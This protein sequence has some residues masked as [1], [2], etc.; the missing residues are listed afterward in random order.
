MRLASIFLTVVAALALAVPAQAADSGFELGH[1]PVP[2]EARAPSSDWLASP[3]D[4][5]RLNLWVPTLE[6]A[7][8]LSLTIPLFLIDPSFVNVGP[9]SSDTF[10]EA[11]TQ[12]PDWDDGDGI[13]ANY[14]LHPF[15]GAEAYLTVRNRGYGP[16]ESFL[17]ATAVSFMWEYVFE[18]WVQHPSAVDL[19]TTSPIGSLQG[20]LRFQLRRQVA[21]WRPSLGRDA[22]LILVDPIEAIHRYAGKLL[23]KPSAGTTEE[24]IDSALD[25]APDQASW[26]VT[27]RY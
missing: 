6:W 20:E 10:A 24:A 13:V 23:R 18:A 11:W 9:L 8:C 7:T 22:L 12:P 27:L 19:V 26:R 5:A 14:V 2:T 3:P 21:Q 17:F 16:V 15:M 25:F 4:P 1:E